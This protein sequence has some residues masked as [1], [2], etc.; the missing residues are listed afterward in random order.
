MSHL[1]VL[2][3]PGYHKLLS[4]T[5]GGM[6]PAPT[7][8]Q[9]RGLIQNTTTFYHR[10]GVP[11][12]KIAALAASE[13][14]NPGIPDTVEAALLRDLCETGGLGQCLVEGPL[15]FDIAVGRA[16]A[17]LKGCRSQ[18][19]GDV[20]VLLVPNITAGNLF[21]KGL[22]LWGGAKMAGCV[23]GARAPIVLV[24]RGASVE[25]KVLSIM[26]CLCAG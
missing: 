21:C 25:E 17:D 5:D 4:V 6:I 24:S 1:A 3:V 9:K 19:S 16:A 22:L 15:S 23:L 2:E 13:S 7:L 26:L 8:E 10:L 20:D 11:L 18:I 12:P 14:V